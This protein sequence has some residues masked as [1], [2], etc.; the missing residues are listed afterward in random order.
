MPGL[1]VQHSTNPLYRKLLRKV[2]KQRGISARQLA[3]KIGVDPS[4]L[5][6]I[7]TGSVPPPAWDKM[8]AINSVLNCPELLEAGEYAFLKDT[9][10]LSL[11]LLGRLTEMPANLVNEFGPDN[12]A[13]WKR[14]C[15]E[16]SGRIYIAYDRRLRW[17]DVPAKNSR[18]RTRS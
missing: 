16:M 18:R 10:W 4:Y 17:E 11:G 13:A 5:S 1:Q 14:I 8:L 7:E 12:I 6:K 15:S 3:K 9:V 2:R